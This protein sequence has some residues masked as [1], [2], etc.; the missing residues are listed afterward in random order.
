[1]S[2]MKATCLSTDIVVGQRGTVVIP[3]GMR[4]ALGIC[5]GQKLFAVVVDGDIVLRPVSNDPIE[6]LRE[7]FAGVFT[8]VDPVEYVRA[9]R[10]EWERQPEKENRWQA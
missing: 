3:A 5:E 7:A 1:M 9:L 2:V 8:G 6:R 4:R 10:R